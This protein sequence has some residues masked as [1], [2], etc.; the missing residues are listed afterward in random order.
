MQLCNQHSG[1]EA[2][3]DN[4]EKSVDALESKLNALILLILGVMIEVPIMVLI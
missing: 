1:L 2:R 3:I 4:L